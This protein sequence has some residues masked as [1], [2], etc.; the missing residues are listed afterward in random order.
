MVSFDSAFAEHAGSSSVIR[1]NTCGPAELVRDVLLKNFSMACA[2]GI[3]PACRETL[4]SSDPLLDAFCT[5]VM[6]ECIKNMFGKLV[7]F[8]VS[9]LN[10]QHPSAKCYSVAKRYDQLSCTIFSVIEA[11]LGAARCPSRACNLKKLE[12]LGQQLDCYQLVTVSP[13]I[14]CQLPGKAA[15]VHDAGVQLCRR[16]DEASRQ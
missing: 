8:K 6:D 13:R 9:C 12:A 4:F 2:T 3:E 5:A 16:S 1:R 7:H 14:S 10:A 11:C 15:D